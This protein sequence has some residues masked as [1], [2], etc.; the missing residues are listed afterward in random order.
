MTTPR[1]GLLRYNHKLLAAS[2]HQQES[3]RSFSSARSYSSAIPET[4]TMTR[5]EAEELHSYQ[6]AFEDSPTVDNANRLFEQLNKYQM[7]MTV[8]RL[9][10]DHDMDSNR[11]KNS[12]NYAK[13]RGEFEY[14]RDRLKIFAKTN[15]KFALNEDPDEI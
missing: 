9:Y 5:E 4:G 7:F 13:M 14:A 1:L 11:A 3:R 12:K 8:V 10:Y 15:P 6:S 2:T